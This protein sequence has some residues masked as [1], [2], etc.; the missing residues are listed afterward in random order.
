MWF[1]WLC[2]AWFGYSSQAY[3]GALREGVNVATCA[4][5]TP[6]NDHNRQRRRWVI[7]GIFA[8]AHPIFL[9][10]WGR[11]CSGAWEQSEDATGGTWRRCRCWRGLGIRG[12]RARVEAGAL[13][14]WRVEAPAQ[15]RLLGQQ[16]WRDKRIRCS[17]TSTRDWA[18]LGVHWGHHQQ[19]H[20]DRRLSQ[21]IR[22]AGE[23]G[24]LGRGKPAE[25]GAEKLWRESWVL[26]G[27]RWCSLP[28][29]GR[30]FSLS[31]WPRA[32]LD[33]PW[34]AILPQT[35]LIGSFAFTPDPLS[36]L[37]PFSIMSLAPRPSSAAFLL[38]S[39][40]SSP[41]LS[42]PVPHL[43]LRTQHDLVTAL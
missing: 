29:S 12:Y 35:E 37:F 11:V 38:Q 36:S 8:S 43:A 31:P 21:L 26:L 33:S 30:T 10:A 24:R 40:S 6:R 17:G 23:Q 4:P 22:S 25:E 3:F 18:N 19:H 5:P 1:N 27:S 7:E 34:E 20:R 15:S 28:P 13:A 39:P 32:P 16:P 2:P 41:L 42:F 9:V 14:A